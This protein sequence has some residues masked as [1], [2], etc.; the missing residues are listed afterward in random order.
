MTPPT[1]FTLDNGMRFIVA[2]HRAAP[3]VAVGLWVRAGACDEPGDRRGMAHFLEHMMFRGSRNIAPEEHA[4][5]IARRGGDCNAFTSSDATVYYQTVPADAIAEVFRLEAD[6]FQQLRLT[7][8]YTDIERRVILEELHAYENQPLSRA[9]MT[10][11][12]EI[13]G[14]HPYALEPL[15]RCPDLEETTTADL[16]LFYHRCYR[17]D[18]IA[19]VVCGD[20]QLSCIQ[21]LAAQHFGNWS[22]PDPGATPPETPT[23]QPLIGSLLRRLP[24]ELPVVAQIYRTGPLDKI[25]KSALELLVALLSSGHASPLRQA[26]VRES[27]LCVEASG[28]NMF[29]V[30]GGLLI[31]F[32][33]FLPPGRHA[34]RR[35]RIKALVDELAARGPD[36]DQFARH[37]KAFRKNR[38][39]DGYSCRRRMMGLGH[40]ELLEGG[41]ETYERE[42]EELAAVTPARIQTLV[43]TLCT[44]QNTLELDIAPESAPWWMTPVGLFRRMWPR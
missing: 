2:E 29:G 35:A 41:F 42:L 23:F 15:G 22:A 36:P 40:A 1:H 44:P 4:R 39:R 26:L 33:A 28:A 43:R 27:R 18:R 7:T 19:A 6:R 24:I 32:G 25:D 3:V 14:N 13:G 5:T 37:L 10:I 16:E 8:E 31:L 11:R 34:P 9:L 20:V 21:D 30:C 17:P 12:Q 38:A